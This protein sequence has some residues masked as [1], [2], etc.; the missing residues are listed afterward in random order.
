MAPGIFDNEIAAA[1]R[2][3]SRT[4]AAADDAYDTQVSASMH[5]PVPVPVPVGYLGPSR[6]MQ[7]GY[8]KMG[9]AESTPAEYWEVLGD[10]IVNM[11]TA[12]R[13]LS[14]PNLYAQAGQ[15]ERVINQ[16]PWLKDVDPNTKVYSMQSG[17]TPD[18]LGFKHLND[19][20]LNALSPNSPFPQ[21]LR[22]KYLDLPNLSVD[23]AVAKVGQINAWRAAQKAELNMDKATNPATALYKDY[24]EDPRG[25]KWMQLKA[26]QPGENLPPGLRLQSSSGYSDNQYKD[27]D[28]PDKAKMWRVVD[29]KGNGADNMG[30]GGHNGKGPQGVKDTYNRLNSNKQLRE[31]MQY[32]GDMMKHCIAGDQYCD[33][34][35]SG[36]RTYYS[37]R[38]S[39]GEPHATIEVSKGKIPYASPGITGQRYDDLV[40]EYNDAARA[41]LIDPDRID[42]DTYFWNKNNDGPPPDTILQI[43]GKLNKKPV[44]KYIPYVQ[45]FVKSGKWGEVGDLNNTGLVDIG[46][47]PKRVEALGSRYVTDTELSNYLDSF[48]NKQS[49]E[50]FAEGGVVNTSSEYNPTK[51]QSLVDSLYEEM[52]G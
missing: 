35:I 48:P 14:D 7:E 13:E 27:V 2:R 46:K 3:A 40:K 43:K 9:V 29:E 16:N 44:E 12:G 8:P 10:E 20:L 17:A 41:G 33:K 45:D 21:D 19:E 42:V 5:M 25:M 30:W 18:Y 24:P 34:A 22:L 51:I 37:L 23:A 38:D 52:N 49:P 32:E 47:T 11:R 26:A 6:R 50:G 31:A 28:V 1:G 36:D 4:R 15:A 39:K